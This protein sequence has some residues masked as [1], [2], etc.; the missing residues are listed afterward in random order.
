MGSYA[1]VLMDCDV[2]TAHERADRS[3]DALL[4]NFWNG[5]EQYLNALSPSN[6]SITG[7]WTF[8]QAFD[9]VLDGVE[10]TDGQG[11][12]E[13]IETFYD[14]R[15]A[16][17]W[18]VG[19]FD[20]EAW[21][22]LALIRAHDLTGEAEY[23][24]QAMIIYQDIIDEGWDETCCPGHAGGIW[25]DKAHTQKATASNGGPVIAGVRLWE[26]TDNSMYLDFA[27]QVYQFWWDHMVNQESFEIFDHMDPDGSR[28]FG[29]LTYN[30]GLMISAALALHR[31]TGQAHYLDEAHGFGDYLSSAPIEQSSV[32][33]VLHDDL[34]T[35]CEGDCAAW[36]GIG[37]RYLVELLAHDPNHENAAQY[38]DVLES[39]VEAMWTLA[40]ND[41]D[42]FGAFWEGPV[43]TTAGVE[44]QG[45]AAMALNLYAKLC[46]PLTR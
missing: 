36:K 35:E 2:A 25:W 38:R 46:G 7:Y 11:Y 23:L 34:G 18:L 22:T 15:E 37:F 33:P 32:G 29:D 10:R 20:D 44:A 14:G 6:G 4:S 8:A 5:D 9:A 19:F 31:A 42:L 21:M 45:S 30:H 13:W 1:A 16:R 39:S 28:A 41:S 3:L 17:G 27:E 26:R 12:S 43:P 40:R 24:D